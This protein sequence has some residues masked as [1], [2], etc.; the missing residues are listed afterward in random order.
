MPALGPQIRPPDTASQPNHG[1]ADAEPR[2]FRITFSDSG[3][4]FPCLSDTNVLEGMAKLGLRGIPV[5]CKG[6]GCGVCKIEVIGGEYRKGVMSRSHV[7][8]EDER[9]NE[10]LACRVFP[11]SDLEI[12]VSGKLKK[13]FGLN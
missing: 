8:E 4:A 11:E 10:V 7:S 5:G 1:A 2:T 9:R 13:A 12:R 6:G 3:V